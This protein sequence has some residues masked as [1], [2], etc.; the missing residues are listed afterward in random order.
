MASLSLKHIFKVYDGKV[1]AVNDFSMDIN[2]KEFIV[3]V[4]PSGCGKST[5]L[6]MIAG[7]EDITAG[8]LRIDDEIVNDYEPKDRNI[9]MV[10]QNYALYPHMSVYENM[11]FSLRTAH[12]PD[13][14]IYIKVT[15]AAEILGITEY[16]DR[17]P[18]ALS[19]GQRQRVALGRAIVRNPK[20]FLLDEPLSNLDA[21]LRTVMRTEISR[22]HERL[23]TTFIYVTHDQ[24]EA[25]TMGTRIVVMKD[26]YVQQIDTPVNLYKYPDNMFVA[27]FIGTPQMNFFD[28]TIEK[29]NDNIYFNLDC[30]ARLEV[31]YKIADKIPLKYM[32]NRTKVVLG[33]RPDAVRMKSNKFID[34]GL[35]APNKA[36]VSAVEVLGGETIVYANL[37]IDNIDS[38][39]GAVILKADPDVFI[40]RG[41]IID[42]EISKRKF[43]VFDK[44]TECSIRRRIP[45]ENIIKCDI[46]DG[47]I[48]FQNQLF[49]L[50]DAI[51]CEDIY[52]VEMTMPIN[53]LT[54]GNGKGK[55]EIEWIEE[56][57]NKTLYFLKVEE[58]TLFSI[59]EGSPKY[60]IGDK[61][62]FDIDL[63]KIAIEECNIKPLTMVN[64]LPG[65]FIK[66]KNKQK[67]YDFY[68]QIG[69]TKLV[70]ST[71]ICEKLFACKG[72][73]IFNT[74][75]LY[76]FNTS[77]LSVRLYEEEL[78]NHRLVGI[79]KEVF[80]Y[81]T[82]KYA[83]IDVESGIV[84]A[85]YDGKVNDKVMIDIDVDKITI[86]DK[87]VNIIIV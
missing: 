40:K 26:G 31:P 34:D 44:K 52:D 46:A 64:E 53:A 10:F 21:K 54:I 36:I 14:E 4:G 65:N 74:D 1:K 17:K 57:Q 50:P 71:R 12:V 69:S 13:K 61:V 41:D 37:N 67:Q 39:L 30:G 80:D 77:D 72:T 6:R 82:K 11:A 62:N 76:E 79:V 73:K 45:Q 86:K 29:V 81:G 60:K 28:S 33:L 43:H 55:A 35:W 85:K 23:E 18:K 59:K 32:D 63:C 25:M 75:L 42:I 84:L 20:V 49:D 56:I 15:E 2:D 47:K 7:L 16:L 68:I 27:G 22:L 58:L 70:P 83:K 38:S 5:T 8:E 24:V 3:F 87:V 78:A 51:K 9:A 66:V 19:G 48:S